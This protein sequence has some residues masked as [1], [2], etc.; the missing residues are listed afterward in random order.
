MS[1]SPSIVQAGTITG[2]I[3][4]SLTH[5]V[6]VPQ[7]L[8]PAPIWFTG[9]SGEL[10]KITDAL[11]RST[12]SETSTTTAIISG[13]GG[14]GKT[15]LALHWAYQNL[16]RFPDGQLF[17]DLCG[18]SPVGQ[19]LTSGAA[20]SAFLESL[21]VDQRAIPVGLAA[22]VGLFRSLVAGKHILI[23]LD[24][25]RES[26]QVVPLLPG[27]AT[28]TVLVTSRDRL[29]GL[30]ASYGA[31][32]VRIDALSESDSRRLLTDRLGS[33]LLSSDPV[34]TDE[35]LGW[36]GG[37]PLALSVL[38][39]RVSASQPGLPLKIFAAE[40]RD[41]TTRL[42]A[43]DDGEPRAS[44]SAVLSWSYRGLDG[45]QARLFD[46]LGLTPSGDISLSAAANLAN[47]SDSSAK[48][49]LRSL[50]RASLI[51]QHMSE[52]YRMHDL[53]R[54]YA[55]ERAFGK[56]TEGD[57]KA[58][59]RRLVDYYLHT[60]HVGDRILHPH[61]ASVELDQR[62]PGCHSIDLLDQSSAWTWFDA[63]HSCLL[64]V[65]R[66]AL[67]QRWYAAVWQLAWVSDTFY[68]RRGRL[69]DHL[70]VWQ[71]AL[72][73]V[74]RID[75]G[76]IQATVHRLFGRACARAGRHTVA[77]SHLQRALVSAEAAGD[78]LGQAHTHHALAWLLEQ[79]GDDTHALEHATLALPHYRAI[80]DP[81]WEARA[82]GLL[83][84]YQARLK[85]NDQAYATLRNA[86]SLSRH[87]GYML[88]EAESLDSLGYLAH[89]TSKHAQAFRYYQ[90][91][92]RLYRTLE[93]TYDEADILDRLAET[94]YALDQYDQARQTWTQA[95]ELYRTQQRVADA[96]RVERLL[97]Q[98]R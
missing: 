67:D 91:A 82:L 50:E 77:M 65:Q 93:H 13:A 84:W 14:M 26:E 18:F 81:A 34:A 69:Y 54:L 25:A 2:G 46:L 28:C 62:A 61:R 98:C 48:A 30:T 12:S 96:N 22:Q 43:L 86:L 8:P 38:I 3:H 15:S 40:L 16:Q 79:A 72:D 45:E 95:L 59:M 80:N 83:G 23:V 47:L 6:P 5:Q 52:R 60:A 31:D 53:L 71:V 21:G 94:L 92:L 27:S 76:A 87:H 24:N 89:N 4:Y 35:L 70:V 20:V 42:G 88:G 73:A 37:L 44:L 33:T 32:L 19:P 1:T 97:G 36:C 51:Q 64:A 78:R 10:D 57:R 29:S 74:S 58:A 17:I 39:G 41:A 63:E 66:M 11:D 90:H 49:L 56:H 9:R 55:A 68:T 7:Q 85:H 75:D